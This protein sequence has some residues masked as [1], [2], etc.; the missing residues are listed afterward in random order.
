LLVLVAA[1]VVA[2]APLILLVVAAVV[3][4]VLD[5]LA[6][7]VTVLREPQVL[8]AVVV[9][10]VQLELMPLVALTAVAEVV[11]TT[12]LGLTPTT[13]AVEP[14]ETAQCE[15]FGPEQLAV[16]HQLTQAIFN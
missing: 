1:G 9:L 16:S 15:L 11:D 12:I 5:F 6:K 4:E 10:A 13:S 14:V 8:V 3:A 7:E 2:V